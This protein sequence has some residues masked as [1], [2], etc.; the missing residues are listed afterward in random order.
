MS[1]GTLENPSV[2]AASNRF[3]LCWQSPDRNVQAPEG[4]EDETR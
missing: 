4:D 3:L 1:R 2:P